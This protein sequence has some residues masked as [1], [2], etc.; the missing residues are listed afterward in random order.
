MITLRLACCTVVIAALAAGCAS[1]AAPAT[2]GP[3][4]RDRFTPGEQ[5]RLAYHSQRRIQSDGRPRRGVAEWPA[6]PVGD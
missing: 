5:R 3:R 4:A 2:S 1:P 6:S